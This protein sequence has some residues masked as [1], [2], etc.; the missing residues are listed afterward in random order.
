MKETESLQFEGDSAPTPKE[1]AEIKSITRTNDEDGKLSSLEIRNLLLMVLCFT[2]VATSI[3]LVMGGSAV[4]I[5][6]VGGS[7]SAAPLGVSA[8]FVGSSLVSLG[9]APLFERL[10]RR[11]GFIV[12]GVLGLIGGLIGIGAIVAQSTVLVIVACLPVGLA[13][14]VGLHLRFA[15]M[16]VVK[17]SN[18][19]FATTLVLSGG[20]IAAFLGP[21][22]QAATRDAFGEDLTYMGLFMM[23]AILNATCAILVFFVQ[24]PNEKEKN[25]PATERDEEEQDSPKE[26]PSVFRPLSLL[27]RFDFISSAMLAFLAWSIMVSPMSIVRIVMNQLGYS[28]RLGLLTLELH[29]LGMYAPGFVTGKLIGKFGTTIMGWVGFILFCCGLLLN[30]LS[31]SPEKGTVATWI[32]VLVLLGIGWNI[33]FASATMMLAK[34][35]E[36]APQNAKKTQAANDFIM[37]GLTCAFV[38]SVG[39]IFKGGGSGLEGWRLVNKVVIG[40]VCAMVTLMLAVTFI[41]KK[42]AEIK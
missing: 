41:G 19:A 12:G 10:G 25:V 3:T 5:V 39:Y 23:V 16:E 20:C 17:E 4:T 1:G 7:G 13:S 37:F 14:G 35:Y 15:A 24:F 8:F 32:V 33:A 28:P 11:G 21:E 27:S 34:T 18:R 30:M 31:Q 9:T 36:N 2:C 38:V 40:L 6:S 22:S 26:T 42:G 29:F